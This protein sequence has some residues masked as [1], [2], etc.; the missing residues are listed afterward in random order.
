[1]SPLDVDKV[2]ALQHFQFDGDAAV[3]GDL[4]VLL[5]PKYLDS[6]AYHWDL[7]RRRTAD[8]DGRAAACTH[9]SH[10]DTTRV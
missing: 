9:Q 4:I 6:A 2:D 8:L 7:T 3:D 5:G 10:L 1:M